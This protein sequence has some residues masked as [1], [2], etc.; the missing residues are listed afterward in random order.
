[1]QPECGKNCCSVSA[2]SSESERS[3]LSLRVKN[4]SDFKCV[5]VTNE[6]VDPSMGSPACQKRDEKL[7]TIPNN[8]ITDLGWRKCDMGRLSGNQQIKENSQPSL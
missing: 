6:P 3:L 5:H 7:D 4:I 2:K 8:R 1:M